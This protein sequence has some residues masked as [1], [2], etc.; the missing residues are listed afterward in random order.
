MIKNA[1]VILLSVISLNSFGQAVS[2]GSF[3]NPSSPCPAGL[4]SIDNATDWS[5]T[6]NNVVGDTCSSTDLFNTCGLAGVV[7]VPN[8]LAGSQTAHSGNAYAGI[9]VYGEPVGQN[10]REY[11]QNH[12]TAPLVA[13][14][15]YCLSVW[16]SLADNS[17]FSIANFGVK[18]TPTPI[19]ISCTGIGSTALSDNGFTPDVSYSGPQVDD[20]DCWT[21]LTFD[22]TA[23]GGEEYVTFGNFENAGGTT[24]A[25][26]VPASTLPGGIGFSGE[27]SSYYYVD[28]M[29]LTAGTCCN[30]AI[31]Y[32]GDGTLC[33][34]DSPVN[35]TGF[36]SGGTWTGTGITNASAGTFDPATAGAGTHTITHTLPCGD[37]ETLDITVNVCLEVCVE[38]NGDFT[39]SN[40]TGPYTWSNQTT[41]VDCSGCPL[42]NC[43]PN[44]CDGVTVISWVPFGNG[45]TITPSGSF[46]IQVE[47]ANGQT[48]EIANA[49]SLQACSSTPPCDSTINPF[50]PFC[51][52]DLASNLSAVTAGGTWSGTGI[53][54]G[55]AGTF[56]PATAGAGTHTITYTLTCGSTNT[57]DV[58]VNSCGN[59]VASFTAS[60]TVLCENDCIDFTNQTTGVGSSATYSW[61]F[62]G[63]TTA[64]STDQH[65]TNIC[66]P[67]VG[68]Y[69]V[70]LTV[71]DNGNTDDTTITSYITVSSCTG[72]N[73][74]F[75]PSDDT[76]CQTGCVTFTNNSTGSGIANFGWNFPGGNPSTFVGVTPPQVCFANPG[77]YQVTLVAADASNN[78]LGTQDVTIVVEPCSVPTVNFTVSQQNICEN[79]CVNFTDQSFGI[80]GSATYSWSFPGANTPTSTSQNPTNICYPNIGTYEVTLAV[81]DANATGD[82]TITGLITVSEC[83]PPVPSFT[84]SNNNICLGSCIDFTNT[85]TNSDSYEWIFDGGF[86]GG[87]TDENPTNICFNTEGVFNISLIAFNSLTSDTIIQTVTVSQPPLLTISDDVTIIQGT[88]TVLSIETDGVSYVWTPTT[89]LSCEDCLSTVAEPDSTTL[90]T[91]SVIADNGCA[92]TAEVLVTVVTI[93]AIGVPSAFSPNGDQVNDILFVEGAGIAKMNFNIYNRYG[94]KVFESN[95]QDFGWDGKFKGKEENPGVFAY[96][97]EY[98]LNNG[99]TGVMKGN[100]TL[101]K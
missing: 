17:H 50:G 90:Y 69:A 75:T 45:A 19:N 68:T 39:V 34:T 20:T 1:F 10:Y 82:T 18:F 15:T 53:T 40:G 30:A 101:V 31:D 51:T 36:V 56:D 73:V 27:N 38:S 37:V 14:Q 63:A 23:T 93:E 83:D 29:E 49:G 95:D 88:N 5:N 52:T 79:D 85:S 35:F 4:G 91:V 66:Y 42:G 21:L 62:T 58:V 48:F 9:L 11:V 59:P 55:T 61:T 67:A 100:I 77:S 46:P 6:Y 94:Q 97:L 65:P 80:V 44:I 32:C 74:D 13:G 92:V 26:N 81:T 64:S 12:L 7:S 87:S 54:S 22:Y 84:I 43:I 57:I 41:T 33:T 71:T 16:V 2:N 78:P 3:E 60:N 86:P 72:V 28:D 96:T 70:S 47:D 25:P 24:T 89:G 8:N 98:V 76:I 99:E